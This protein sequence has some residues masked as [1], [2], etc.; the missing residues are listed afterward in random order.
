M[1]ESQQTSPQLTLA[2][3]GHMAILKPIASN[4]NGV[5]IGGRDGGGSQPPRLPTP[6]LFICLANFFQNSTQVY[7]LWKVAKEKHPSC[8]S[9]RHHQHQHPCPQKCKVFHG[10]K[11]VLIYSGFLVPS[12]VPA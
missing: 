11:W 5:M 9:V 12:S 10:K 3:I 4:G 1:L 8:V 7:V 2:R 6:F